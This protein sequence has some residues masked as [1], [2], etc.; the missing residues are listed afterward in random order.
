MRPHAYLL[1]LLALAACDSGRPGPPDSECPNPSDC[2]GFTQTTVYVGNQGNFTENNGT[3]TRYDLPEGTTLQDAVRVGEDGP[4]GG[5]VQALALAPDGRLVVL[6]NFSTGGGRL[7]VADPETDRVVAQVDVPNPRGVAFVGTRAYVSSLFE[8]TV[9]PVDLATGTAGAP[10]P[11]GANPEGM[12]AVGSR[13][14]VANSGFGADSTVSV[15]DATTNRR[16]ETINVGCAG[17]RSLAVDAEAEV[18]VFCTGATDFSTGAVIA[19]GEAVVLN[20]QT[21]A[22][23]ARIALTG[24]LGTASLGQDASYNAVNREIYVVQGQSALR[25][26]TRTNALAATVG[27]GPEPVG[28]IA[29]DALGADG[30]RFYVARLDAQ[31]PYTAAGFVSVHDRSGARVGVFPAGVVPSAIAVLSLTA[32]P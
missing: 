19:N 3:V 24:T 22:V 23:V 8:N 18:W 17:P 20:G 30:P 12:A 2:D 25:F 16:V 26:D 14:Y 4:L 11:V 13:V 28:G 15:I 10:I 9:T 21:G 27:L 32:L 7:A 1:A 6:L 5:L 31:N 29:Y